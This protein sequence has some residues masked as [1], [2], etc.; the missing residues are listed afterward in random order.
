M[1]LIIYGWNRGSTAQTISLMRGWIIMSLGHIHIYC[2]DDKKTFVTPIS[3][4]TI[5]HELNHYQ[6]MRE[7]LFLL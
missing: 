5:C 7:G 3:N 1:L 6:L 2:M 4:L